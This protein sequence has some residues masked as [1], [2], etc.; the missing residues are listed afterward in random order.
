[1]LLVSL[2]LRK[3]LPRRNGLLSLDERRSLPEG[4]ESPSPVRKKNIL[5]VLWK[6]KKTSP[7]PGYFSIPLKIL[8]TTII[9][10]SIWTKIN[11]YHLLKGLGVERRV[12]KKNNNYPPWKPD[13]VW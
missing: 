5:K 7:F 10:L 11:S 1:M 13:R 12:N 4:F 6:M 2:P 8:L 3:E 9:M